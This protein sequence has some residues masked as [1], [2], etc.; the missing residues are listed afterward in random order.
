M[1]QSKLKVFIGID[2]G[3]KGGIAV[4]VN[5]G[6]TLQY[7]IEVYDLNDDSL[8]G[9]VG[10]YVEYYQHVYVGIEKQIPMPNQ[11]SVATSKTFFNYGKLIG[12]LDAVGVKFVTITPQTWMKPLAL[13]KGMEKKERKKEICKMAG[14]FYPDVAD[15]L[16]GPRGGILDGRSDALMI[17]KY[18]ERNYKK[19]FKL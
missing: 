17:M 7:D 15:K 18:T 8:K 9:N 2:P 10:H 3:L 4:K 19:L 13:K 16:A 11:S 1:R 14:M 6:G 12:Y 5:Y